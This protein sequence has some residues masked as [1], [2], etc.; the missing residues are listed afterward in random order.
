MWWK[1]T[2][3]I[4]HMFLFANIYCPILQQVFVL[5]EGKVAPFMGVHCAVAAIVNHVAKGATSLF[6]ATLSYL[7][8]QFSGEG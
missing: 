2:H 8:H 4:A 6:K 7:L 3:I 5:K 1:S